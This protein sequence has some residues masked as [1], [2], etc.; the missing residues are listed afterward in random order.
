MGDDSLTLTP[1]YSMEWTDGTVRRT[2]D[3]D[4]WTEDAEAK[5]TPDHIEALAAEAREHPDCEVTLL[6]MES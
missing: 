5:L 1:V 6:G 4:L 3:D 2:D